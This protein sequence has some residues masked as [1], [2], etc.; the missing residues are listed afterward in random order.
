MR[1]RLQFHLLYIVTTLILISCQNKKNDNHTKYPIN[2]KSLVSRHNPTIYK[3][4]KLS[5]FTVGNG[6]FAFTA[7]VTGL[8]TF[9]DFYENGIPLGSQSLWGWHTCPN[10]KNYT[11]EQA[12]NFYDTYGRQVSYAS[13]MTSE[14]AQWLR[15]N[16][17]RLHL[18][19][20]GFQIKGSDG[21]SIQL[22]DIR[23]IHQTLNLWEGILHSNFTVENHQIKAETCCHP[24][25]DQIAD[26]I[27]SELV[28][29]GRLG[30]IFNFPYGSLSWGKNSADWEN[31]DKHET[32]VF[33]GLKWLGQMD[34]KVP[35]K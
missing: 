15:S 28:D 4:D 2:R 21:S 6:E 33:V 23:D 16:P 27:H 24:Q 3:A 12:F 30:V 31:P 22:I 9:M 20:V 17:H 8:Q 10:P 14:A 34:G 29:K 32:M 35:P 11:L 1:K 25:L 26:R 5:P 18:G 13:D 19:Q 7:D